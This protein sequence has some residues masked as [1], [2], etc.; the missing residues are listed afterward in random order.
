MQDMQN[1]Q[2]YDPSPQPTPVPWWKRRRT[3]QLAGL[4]AIAG[5]VLVFAAIAATNVLKNRQLANEGEDLMDQA[6]A[7]ESQLGAKCTEGDEGCLDRA[8]SDAARA[9]GLSQA[10]DELAGESFS[11]CVTLICLLYTSDAADE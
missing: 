7:I 1:Y 2:Y 11:T 8:R 9:L 6:D 4:L 10:C 3:W 5:V